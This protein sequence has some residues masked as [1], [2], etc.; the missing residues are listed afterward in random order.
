MSTHTIVIIG[1]SFGGLAVAHGLLKTVLPQLPN[2]EKQ[3]YKV[4]QIAPNDDFFWKIAA[5]RV[6]A[7]PKSIPLEKTLIPIASGFKAYS[8]DQYE[9]I[10]AYVTSIDPAS[11]TVHTSTSN[12]VH[13]DSLV[14]AS[15]TTFASHVWTVTDGSEPLKEAIDEIHQ[16]L[17]GAESVLIAGGGAAGVETAGEFGEAF[18]KKKEITLLSGSTGLLS[19][20]QNKKMGSD[21]QSRLEKMGVKVLNDNLRV[22]EH[23]TV[24]GKDVLKL[25][26]GETKTVDIYIEATGDKPNSK[27]LP[28]EWLD[29]KQKVKT[30]AQT[31]HLDVPGV[32]GVYVFGSVGSYSDGSVLDIKF[33]TPAILESIK[34]DLQGKGGPRTAK[35]YKKI[36]SDM[37]FVPIGSQGGVGIAFGWKL[38]SFLVKLAK[39]KDFMIGNAVKTVEGTA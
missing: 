3:S 21:A 27:F 10:R 29:D 39:A 15:G 6:I 20:L 2:P 34:L 19:R 18:G 28:Q 8:K 24:N 7:N 12:A 26:N 30:N 14:I 23:T 16:K 35:I 5:P 38:P 13:Y 9:F 32:T 22:T 4:V 31:L 1:A 37:Q 36:Q 11:K 33:A 25:S 17:P